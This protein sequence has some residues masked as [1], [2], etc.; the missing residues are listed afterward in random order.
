M[1]HQQH[2]T[3]PRFRLDQRSAGL[4]VHPTSLAAGPG[5]PELGSGDLGASARALVDFAAASG[6]GW[7]Q[8]LPVG[9]VGPGFSP[10]SSTSVFAGEP[11]LVSLDALVDDGLLERGDPALAPVEPAR[12]VDFVA[13]RDRRQGALR[14]AFEKARAGLEHDA[15]YASF[16]EKER[17]WLDDYAAF[18]TLKEL[19][20][21]KPYFQ[22]P[23][24]HKKRAPEAMDALRRDHA[25]ALA[26]H[27][28]V[29]HRFAR[30]LRRL[31]AY[32]HERGVGLM[33]DVPIYVAHDSADVWAHGRFFQLDAEGDPAFVAGVPPD[34]FSD[35]GQL[36]GNPLYDWAELERTDFGFWVARLAHAFRCFDSVRLDHFIGFS[37][38]YAVARGEKS[39]KHGSFHP[40]PG[41]ALFEAVFRSLGP[42]ALV[43]EDLG[44]VTDE[45]RKLRDHFRLPGMNILQFSF[46]PGRHNE[47]SRPHRY[48]QR[49]VVYTGTHDNDTTAGWLGSPPDDA[50]E[51]GRAAWLSDRDYC[52]RYLGLDADKPAG[53][54]AWGVVRAAL[55]SHA[56]TAFVPAQDLL[57]LGR[58]ARMNRPGIAEGN[59]SVRLLPGELDTKLAVRVRELTELYGRAP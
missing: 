20:G 23:E 37:R 45:V 12:R 38:Y 35:D 39:A 40:V 24:A 50:S 34:A 52:L 31:R 21:G 6:L 3:E 36:W 19:H 25:E 48:A 26:F 11:M 57:G 46:S 29:Q 16:L 32:A 5:Q 15:E 41:Y 30:D 22:W 55:A 14:R 1:S 17:Y 33:G 53:E 54:L 8:M 47:G 18:A 59:W 28:F 9:P 13:V 7:W 42:V 49:S 58:E 2:P 4:L 10:Y 56:D 27:R 44:V 43:A 51:A